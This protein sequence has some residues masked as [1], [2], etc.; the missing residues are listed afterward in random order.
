LKIYRRSKEHLQSPT[1]RSARKRE[2]RAK[3]METCAYFSSLKTWAT[4]SSDMLQF[5]GLHSFISL[6][7]EHFITTAVRK[8]YI[9][10]NNNNEK[11][12]EPESIY[13]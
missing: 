5:N 10:E 4:R 3:E 11:T 2:P 7:R 1:I 6:N 8:S 13:V 12:T 9:P